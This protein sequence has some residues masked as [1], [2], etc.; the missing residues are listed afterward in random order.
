MDQRVVPA[1]VY[2]LAKLVDVD[3][4]DVAKPVQ[5]FLCPDVIGD[6][7]TCEGSAGVTHEEYEER[8]FP[9]RQGEFLPLRKTLR[10]TGSRLRSAKQT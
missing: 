2:F 8:E 7:V 1:I 6:G 9:C 3:I 4:D 10:V 5:F